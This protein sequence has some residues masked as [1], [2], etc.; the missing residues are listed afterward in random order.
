MSLVDI[1]LWDDNPGRGYQCNG[2][3]AEVESIVVD[4]DSNSMDVAVVRRT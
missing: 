1:V 3:E 2:P 4:E